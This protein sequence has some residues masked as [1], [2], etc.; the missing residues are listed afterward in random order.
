MVAA[1]SKSKIG[2]KVG[3]EAVKAKTGRVWKDW[4]SLLDTAGAKKMTHQEI[5]KLLHT[6]HGL[7]PWWQQMVTVAYEQDRGRRGKGEKPEGF[8]ISVSRTIE[9]PLANLYQSF[10]NEKKRHSWLRED[11]LVVRTATANKSMRI[12][13][14]DSKTSLEIAFLSKG[15]AKTQVVV[16]HSKLPNA[17][18]AEKMKSYWGKALDRLKESF[19]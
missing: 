19:T 1:T 16:Q 15:P 5:V 12:T 10:A 4:F 9:A 6:E 8:Q 14:K 17:N 2:P 13:W 3:N 18:T 7:G 11:G